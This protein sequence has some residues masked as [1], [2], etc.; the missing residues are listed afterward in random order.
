[1]DEIKAY[2]PFFYKHKILLP[3]LFFYRLGRA[4][5][6]SRKKTKAQLK[7]LKENKKRSQ[8]KTPSL[9]NK[10]E[11]QDEDRIQKERR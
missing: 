4:V 5:T 6:V 1:M 2:H 9:H 8:K 10:E 3:C 7:I 11:K